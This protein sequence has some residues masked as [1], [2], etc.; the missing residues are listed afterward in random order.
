MPWLDAP[1]ALEVLRLLQEALANII[2]H[3]GARSIAISAQG[4]EA[5]VLVQVVDDGVG[6]DTAQPDAGRGLPNMRERARLL[7]GRLTIESSRGGG[8]AVRLWL[9][10]QP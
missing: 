1:Q 2:K 7:G 9:P 8:T 6:F 3:A 10:A 5:G 4:A